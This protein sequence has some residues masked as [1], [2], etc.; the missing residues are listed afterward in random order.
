M[1][2]L[3]ITEDRQLVIPPSEVD[4]MGL[5][6]GQKVTIIEFRGSYRIVPVPEP[7][8]MRGA[9]PGISKGFERERE[10]RV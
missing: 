2:M 7:E 8:E 10:D 5:K 3:S 9:F 6:P 4:A 1:P